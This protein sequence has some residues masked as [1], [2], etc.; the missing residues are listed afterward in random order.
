MQAFL[1]A[2]VP[3][4]ADELTFCVIPGKADAAPL[5]FGEAFVE[6]HGQRVFLRG[7]CEE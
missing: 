3:P 7:T 4:V 5:F 1:W 2:D 6:L